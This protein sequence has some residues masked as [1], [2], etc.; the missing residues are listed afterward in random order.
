MSGY[1]QNS[2]PA[3][4]VNQQQSAMESEAHRQYIASLRRRAPPPRFRSVKYA[5]DAQNTSGGIHTCGCFFSQENQDLVDLQFFRTELA[6]TKV[7]TF[8]CDC[9]SVFTL[10]RKLISCCEQNGLSE[11]N[12]RKCE[13]TIKPS[14][15]RVSYVVEKGNSDR[16]PEIG[17]MC[18]DKNSVIFSMF[19]LNQ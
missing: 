18:F 16:L 17:L 11:K 14:S 12:F 19:W 10:A 6:H 5:V 15:E 9:A 8:V 3:S 1:Q 7:M 4:G 13:Y 2:Y